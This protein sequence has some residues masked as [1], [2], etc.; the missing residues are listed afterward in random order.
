MNNQLHRELVQSPETD[1][2]EE[3]KKHFLQTILRPERR[4]ANYPTQDVHT[5][6]N[7]ADFITGFNLGK[8]DWEAAAG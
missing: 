7:E 5:P 8:A 2:V 1:W 6:Q 4:P 3:G